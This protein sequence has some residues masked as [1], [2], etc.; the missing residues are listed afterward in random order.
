MTARKDL[1]DAQILR[2]QKCNFRLYLPAELSWRLTD[3]ERMEAEA[4]IRKTEKR[5][6]ARLAQNLRRHRDN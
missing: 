3:Q 1:T 6:R 5:I 2:R 4:W